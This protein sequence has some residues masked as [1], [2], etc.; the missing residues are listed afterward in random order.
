M[1]NVR[2]LMRMA[3]EYEAEEGRDL[4]RFI[5]FVAER[6]LVQE[7]EGQAPLE[8]EDLDA[9]RVMTIHRAKGLE[10]PVVCVADLGKTGRED[11][12]AL[13]INHDGRVGI[14]LAQMGGGSVDSSRLGQIREESKLEGEEEE[15]RIFYVAATRAQDHLV[16]SGATDLERLK[17]PGPLDEPMRWLWRALAPELPE[18]GR[19]LHRRDRCT[20]GGP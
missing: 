5:D 8:A 10:F 3:R 14:R 12:S 9:V 4:R 13:R 11:D 16:L 1:A 15:R 18:P 7:Q 2:K 17:E 19:L 6:D 20:T